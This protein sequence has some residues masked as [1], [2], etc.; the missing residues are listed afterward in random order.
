M[1]GQIYRNVL[2]SAYAKVLLSALKVDIG[3][4]EERIL[5]TGEV[6]LFSTPC[7]EAVRLQ[8]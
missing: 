8:E 5:R 4:S 1:E 3:D 2:D 6:L 7:P